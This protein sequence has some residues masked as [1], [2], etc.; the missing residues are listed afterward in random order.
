MSEP[1]LIA[2]VVHRLS[3]GGLENGLAN[4]IDRMPRERY[5]HAIV[6]LTEASDFRRRFDER[7]VAIYE[8]HKRPGLEPGVHGRLAALLRR[9]APAIVHTRNFATLE[10]QVTAAAVGVR[11]RIHGEH[12]RD[13]Q[14]LDGTRLK[15]N[16]FRWA[17]QP[18]VH[19]FVAV[20]AELRDWLTGRVGIAERRVRYIAN[21]VDTARFSPRMPGQPSVVPGAGPEHV[22]IGTVGRMETVKDQ[23]TLARAFVQLAATVPDGRQRLRLAMVGDG[24][25]RQDALAILREAGL[26]SLAWLPGERGDIPDVLRSLDVF[27]LP[28]LREG[29]S[30]TVLEAMSCGLPVVATRV[31]ANVELVEDGVTGAL[32]EP[33]RPRDMAD[34]IGGYALDATRRAEHGRAGRSR[35]ERHYALQTMVDRYT[36]LYDEIWRPAPRPAWTTKCQETM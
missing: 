36:A 17:V 34:A 21:G 2:H 25:L 1:A 33:G 8:L 30:N 16:L 23:V 24:R 27:V 20:S 10:Y 18:V 28:S 12:G 9:L 11:G 15:Y 14:D 3:V 19:R 35:I 7:D 5:R 31:G 29:M 32:V 13:V 22:V 6:S 26:A 4:L